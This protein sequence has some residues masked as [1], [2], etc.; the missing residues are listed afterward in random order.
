LG[1]ADF[2]PKTGMKV[3]ERFRAM[4]A[5]ATQAVHDDPG[6]LGAPWDIEG[7]PEVNDPAAHRVLS[8]READP[9]DLA[10]RQPPDAWPAPDAKPA[11]DLSLLFAVDSQGIVC[12]RGMLVVTLWPPLVSADPRINHHALAIQRQFVTQNVAVSMTGL[13]VG[14][15]RP[16]V[17]YKATPRVN[18]T[19]NGVTRIG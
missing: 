1:R 17:E 6:R 12:R 5:A 4:Q 8:A 2:E 19:D 16:R 18:V 3:N 13:V 10:H 11:P 9:L 7:G 14:A 15:E